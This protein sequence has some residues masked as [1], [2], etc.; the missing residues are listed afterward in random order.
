MQVCVLGTASWQ[1][2]L[3][4][5]SFTGPHPGSWGLCRTKSVLPPTGLG[6]LSPGLADFL[7]PRV[8]PWSPCGLLWHALGC[9]LSVVCLWEGGFWWNVQLF[10][11]VAMSKCRRVGS[12]SAVRA[13]LCICHLSALGWVWGTDTPCCR[14]TPV[15]YRCPCHLPEPPQTSQ[16]GLPEVLFWLLYPNPEDPCHLVDERPWTLGESPESPCSFCSSS[17][18]GRGA[19]V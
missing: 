1:L 3:G 4:W 7:M 12:F 10:W 17:L 16:G 9:C 8:F 6:M 14:A 5:V 19:A 2:Y 15:K 11:G 13:L 18:V